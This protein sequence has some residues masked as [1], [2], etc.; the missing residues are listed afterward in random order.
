M[1]CGRVNFLN[2]ERDIMP[3]VM[4]LKKVESLTAYK[5]EHFF[6]TAVL[7][8]RDKT[9]KEMEDGFTVIKAGER[10]AIDDWGA[11]QITV[12]IDTDIFSDI[13]CPTDM[14]CS[15][16]GEKLFITTQ[17]FEAIKLFGVGDGEI[18]THVKGTVCCDNDSCN[19]ASEFEYA[20]GDWTLIE[21]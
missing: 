21:G 3:E 11:V 6:K 13:D 4:H 7:S 9:L 5:L 2:L 8:L 14:K 12:E 1:L 17:D 16:C 15:E 18:I 20:N 10:L 19:S